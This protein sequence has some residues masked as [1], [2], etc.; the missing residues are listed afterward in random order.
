MATYQV[1]GT[2]RDKRTKQKKFQ[3]VKEKMVLID[4]NKGVISEAELEI[5][6]QREGEQNTNGENLMGENSVME[7]MKTLLDQ[8]TGMLNILQL[9]N[10]ATAT[11][12]CLHK[13]YEYYKQQSKIV[14]TAG[15]YGLLH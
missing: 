11:Q 12:C 4:N 1:W 14:A 9:I 7:S 10:Q 3:E 15:R 2:D 5:I 6:Y 8:N 13:Y